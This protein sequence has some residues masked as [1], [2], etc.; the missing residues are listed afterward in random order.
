MPPSVHPRP[1]RPAPRQRRALR[2]WLE[3]RGVL[4]GHERPH[5]TTRLIADD[6]TV[7]AGTYLPAAGGPAAVLLVHGFGA[8]RRKPAYA[9]LADGLGSRL[10]VLALDLRGHGDS[11]GWSTLGDREAHDVAAGIRW[12]RHVGHQRVVVVGL[13]MGA[14]AAMHAAT[15]VEE[16]EALVLVSA[17]SRFR[18][19]PETEPMR[20]LAA[21]WR[22]PSRRR[23]L[24]LAVGVRLAGPEAWG[25]PPHPVQ[26]VARSGRPVLVVHG[27]DDPYF[28]PSD[29]HELVAASAG[30]AALW[31]EPEGFGHAE[32]GL[33]PTFIARLGAAIDSMLTTGRFPERGSGEPSH[34]DR[35]SGAGGTGPSGVKGG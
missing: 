29:A 25:P 22:S 5:V 33:T 24:R 28:P 26:L 10:P 30:H 18:P 19:T 21:V 15:G 31:I 3:T 14:T 1:L 7:L 16:P 35:R 8:H 4:G 23:A 2:R 11:G 13:S 17:T 12:L 32:D 34:H 9:R 27:D 6:G 20:R